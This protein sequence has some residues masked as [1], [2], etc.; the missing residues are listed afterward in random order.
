M[1]TLAKSIARLSLLA[2]ICTF[3]PAAH[4]AGNSATFALVSDVHLNPFDPPEIAAKLAEKPV[5]DW[6]TVFAAIKEQA[7]SPW[8]SDTNHALFASSVAA[9]AETAA[10]TDLA[11]VPGDFLAH[12]FESKAAKALGVSQTDAKVRKLAV[13]TTVF[14]G[15]SISR[16]LPGRPIIV[17]LGNNDSECGDYRI[18]PGGGYLAGTKDMVRRLAGDD[19]LA[20]DFDQTYGAGGY[21][22]VRHPGLPRTLI[23]VVN[24]I[25]WSAKYQDACGAGGEAAAKAMLDWLRDNLANQQA[26]GGSVWLV[27][28][29]PWGIDPFSTVHSKETTCQEKVVPFL[30]APYASAFVDLLREYK[31]IVTASY[32]GH[33]HT[34]DYRLLIDDKAGA[35]A[36]QKIAPAISPIY[37]QNPGF[38]IVDYDLESGQPTNFSTHYLANLDVASLAVPGEWKPEYTFTE[39]YDVPRYS[40]QSVA[41]MVR[42][43]EAGGATADTYRRLYM[44]SHKSLSQADLPAYVC[45]MTR[46]KQDEFTACYC[47]G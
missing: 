1:N 30:R 3:V 31:D 44:V 37:N 21:Y 39:T 20:A 5:D 13:N 14:V 9:I 43:V 29:I 47:G 40:A 32:S 15:D 26:A 42:A 34:D 46:L 24:D 17:A 12:E 35:V 23:L 10:D 38:Q 22:A 18:T 19:L 41:E 4:S 11:I 16:A 6:T 36:A 2:I 28:H 7:M 25:L 33:V 45:A 8:G 27:H